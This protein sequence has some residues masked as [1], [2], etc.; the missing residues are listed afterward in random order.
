MA[1]GRPSKTTRTSRWEWLNSRGPAYA[2]CGSLLARRAF[3]STTFADFLSAFHWSI[4]DTQEPD[5]NIVYEE[6]AD[7]DINA[8]SLKETTIKKQR[9]VCFFTKKC[10]EYGSLL[11]Y[12]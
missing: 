11:S 5:P 10:F 9:E 8:Q 2:A 3:E 4:P 12:L 6:P 1:G 7:N